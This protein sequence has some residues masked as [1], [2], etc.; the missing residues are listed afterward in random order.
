MIT[1]KRHPLKF[2]FTL[3]FS[4]LF[5]F[6]LPI[7]IFFMASN[8]S[9]GEEGPT[10]LILLLFALLMV[11]LGIYM[12]NIYLKNAPSI[13]IGNGQISFGKKVFSLEDITELKLEGKE[14]FPFFVYYP[15][16]AASLIFQ[17][18]SVKHIFGDLYTNA[19]ELKSYLE[20]VIIKKESYQPSPKIGTVSE[21]NIQGAIQAFKKP[22][23]LSMRGISAWGLG[24]YLFFRFG[25]EENPPIEG[26][27]IATVAFIVWLAI[28][29]W[30]MHFPSLSSNYLIIKNHN[31]F[32]VKHVYKL[33]KIREVVFETRSRMPNCIRVIGTDH[34]NTLYPAGTL[35]DEDWLELK[36]ALEKKGVSVRD[37]CISD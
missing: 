32:W 6:G 17:D 11:L 1:L 25:M 34:R 37:E 9:E 26:I 19:W 12:L 21:A 16:E 30:L 15:M 27:L 29:S 23:L 13:Q 36:E 28:A 31:F 24:V 3:A 8:L 14:A 18:G 2:Y 35:W 4:C 22:Q 5:F 10:V 7:F 33:D 20:A